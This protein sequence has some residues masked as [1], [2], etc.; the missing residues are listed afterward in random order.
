MT[1]LTPICNFCGKRFSIDIKTIKEQKEIKGTE[2]GIEVYCPH[3][4]EYI[5]LFPED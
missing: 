1:G 4:G 3:C 5:L 2:N